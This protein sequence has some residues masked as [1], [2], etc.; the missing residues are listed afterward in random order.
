[1]SFGPVRGL[2]PLRGLPGARCDD[3]DLDRR[4]DDGM[5]FAERVILALVQGGAPVIVQAALIKLFPD[6]GDDPPPPAPQQKDDD[7]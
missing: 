1:V 5:S 4:R 7:E 6:L 3:D 2:R